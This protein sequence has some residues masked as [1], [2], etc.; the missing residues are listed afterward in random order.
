VVAFDLSELVRV[1]AIVNSWLA[2]RRTEEA[3]ILA[4]HLDKFVMPIVQF[5]EQECVP[6]V[7]WNAQARI[8]ACV[9][10]LAVLLADSVA[11]EEVLD[12]VVLERYVMFSLAWSVMSVLDAADRVKVDKRFAEI[13]HNM[14]QDREMR[15][16][17]LLEYIM[18][19][20]RAGPGQ[21]Q[22]LW[23]HASS[24]VS[25]AWTGRPDMPKSTIHAVESLI[26]PTVQGEALKFVGRYLRGDMWPL[27]LIGPQGCGKSVLMDGLLAV[28]ERDDRAFMT[29][30]R[31][32]LTV[33]STCTSLQQ[34]LERCLKKRQGR[35]FGPPNKKRMAFIVHDV[36]MPT[37]TACGGQP[38]AELLRDLAERKG[39]YA[40]NQPGERMDIADVWL[41][42]L[43]QSPREGWDA[44]P[45]RLL[46]LAF[47]YSVG[48]PSKDQMRTIFEKL[49][50]AKF[51]SG[52]ASQ[53]LRET[54]AMC[55]SAT[56]ELASAL[57]SELLPYRTAYYT[58][59]CMHSMFRCVRG[60][61][62]VVPQHA[63]NSPAVVSLWVHE[64]RREFG[65][66]LTSEQKQAFPRVLNSLCMS[67]FG[68][69]LES[70][71]CSTSEAMWRRAPAW[72]NIIPI[73]EADVSNIRESFSSR[74]E[75]FS[76]RR[77]SQKFT[78]DNNPDRPLLSNRDRPMLSSRHGDSRMSAYDRAMAMHAEYGKGPKL[79][80]CAMR[81]EDI[82]AQCERYLAEYNKSS[83]GGRNSDLDDDNPTRTGGPLTD[84]DSA[85]APQPQPQPQQAPQQSPQQAGRSAADF[86]GSLQ[87]KLQRPGSAK[88]QKSQSNSSTNTPENKAARVDIL[89]FP[90]VIAHMLSVVR[91]LGMPGCHY[92]AVGPARDGKSSVARLSAFVANIEYVAVTEDQTPR[93]NL[94]DALKKVLV[95]TVL[96]GKDV[97]VMVP[98]D[99]STDTSTLE[100]LAAVIVNPAT[101]DVF[102][103]ESWDAVVQDLA[104]QHMLEQ[105]KKLYAGTAHMDEREVFSRRVRRHFHLILSFSM[106]MQT[107]SERISALPALTGRCTI[108][109]WHPWSRSSLEEFAR[110]EV[111]LIGADMEAQRVNVANAEIRAEVMQRLAEERATLLR[112]QSGGFTNSTAAKGSDD[113]AWADSDTEATV[114]E[115]INTEKFFR[116][117]LFSSIENTLPKQMAYVHF[118]MLDVAQR[119]AAEMKQQVH[120]P[121]ARF[122]YYA[123]RLRE[124][125]MSNFNTLY[126]RNAKVKKALD[127]LDKCEKDIGSLRAGNMGGLTSVRAAAEVWTVFYVC[128]YVCIHVCMYVFMY[129]CIVCGMW[130]I[131]SV[132]MCAKNLKRAIRNPACIYVWASTRM[133]I[134]TLT[135]V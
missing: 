18:I 129:V 100:L 111:T 96:G 94:I 108:D 1:N 48:A 89:L 27:L 107:F 91:V 124:V 57:S 119:Y 13:T 78:S 99:A 105:D 63:P 88:S 44:L 15:G 75:S 5:I 101:Y 92:I 39:L 71:K 117:E 24:L 11:A 130:L 46:Q 109:I 3:D 30:C 127:C 4:V 6:V 104:F 118:K 81:M 37:S 51:P 126:Q 35:I 103:P 26:V 97:A 72:T 90:E 121:F 125:F 123:E 41:C 128:M 134:H 9:R 58:R 83:N 68:V 112:D 116:T 22:Q 29:V 2:G 65:D 31:M 36:N 23:E 120:Y 55:A 76:S 10:M 28:K 79:Y 16:S 62:R 102:S 82:T 113:L 131:I 87:L 50:S 95:S 52:S 14:P 114:N 66:K 47:V 93:A 59:F 85:S 38:T 43:A 40:L 84:G 54:I 98:I 133:T 74:R 122:V 132:S 64:A 49:L 42:A 56:V 73:S 25:K 21:Q 45:Q 7:A 8:R 115:A 80:R 17:T 135:C 61:L 86:K 19:D 12:R 67:L 33:G 69:D 106:P 34:T 20:T 110:G 60:L 70:A 53:H 32:V 77:G